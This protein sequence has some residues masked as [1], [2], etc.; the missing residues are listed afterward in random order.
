MEQHLAV[1]LVSIFLTGFPGFLGATLLERIHER[2]DR[3]D[4]LIQSRYR[5]QA[6]QRAREIVG[7][8]WVE[9]I[10]LHEGDITEPD[11]GLAPETRATLTARTRQVFHLAAVYDLGVDA[12]LAEAVN[13]DGTEH[14]L[15][16]ATDCPDLD[17]FQ[18]VSTCYVS[19]R[20]DGVFGPDDLH[21]DQSF[22][23]HY[24]RTKFHAEQAVQ[25]EMVRGLPT[26]IYR[27][28]IVVGDSQTGETE[29]YDGPYGLL[30]F[31][32]RQPRVAVLPRFLGA[33]R[34]EVNL[35]PRDFV[36]DAIAYL[37]DQ[38]ESVDT[39]YQLCDPH[40]PTV[41]QVTKLFARATDRRVIRVPSS[42][43]VV[44]QALRR[45]PGLQGATAVDPDTVPYFTHPTSYVCPNTRRALADTDIGC[46]PL[47]SY[48]E[49]L[50]AYLRANP[51]VRTD[52]MV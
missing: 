13:V 16:F 33:S 5:E 17:R 28:A 34:H 24:E 26:T 35:V 9:T 31:L 50:V 27:P 37:S 44:E 49:T 51:D 43:R 45:V 14:V 22:S 46:P 23:N 30:R 11:L 39:V 20:H 1:A 52:A 47:A 4:C 6:E 21:V 8:N 19:G 36:V 38:S 29:K 40:P 12:D 15:T 2:T 32:L 25:R 42:S 3:V 10:A 7:P 18:Y 41:S 48:V